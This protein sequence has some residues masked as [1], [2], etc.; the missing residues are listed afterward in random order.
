[1]RVYPVNNYAVTGHE[2]PFCEHVIG[3]VY[4]PTIPLD[5]A[6]LMSVWLVSIAKATSAW[7]GG[8]TGIVIVDRNGIY[9]KTPDEL[10]AL[11]EVS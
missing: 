6:V 5:N 1:M 9:S 4:D 8:A 2:P 3:R 10:K 7:V 11:E